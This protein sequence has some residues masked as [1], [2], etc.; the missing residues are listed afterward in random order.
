MTTDLMY[1][2]MFTKHVMSPGHPERPE[3]LTTAM[4]YIEQT[5]LLQ[6]SKIKLVEPKPASLDSVYPL[7]DRNY[8]EKVRES[9][10]SGGGYFTLDTSVNKHTYDAAILAA[11]AG[12]MAVDRIME[13]H[14]ENAYVLCRPPGHHAEYQKAFGFCFI[15]NIA[16]AALHLIQ[17]HGLER[18][19]IVDYDAHHGNGTQSAFYSSKRVLYVG[20]HQDGRTLFPGSGFPDEIGSEDGEGY[21]VNLAMYPGAGDTSYGLVFS[22]VVEQVSDSFEPEFVLVSTG[23]DGHFSDPLTVLGLT[24]SGIAEM[25]SRLKEIAKKYSKQRIAFFL[26]GGYELDIVGKGS[27]NI[28]E[29]LSGSKITEYGDDHVESQNCTQHTESLI[30]RVKSNLKGIHF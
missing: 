24:T 15:N 11:G 30:S 14:S 25:N 9:S 3:R 19:L 5:G 1:H 29:E 16:V 8:L 6:T 2:E 23:F 18:V 20:L 12:V 7:H 27:Q 17:Q 26:E 13:N 22:E 28:V 10:Q 4:H 21:N